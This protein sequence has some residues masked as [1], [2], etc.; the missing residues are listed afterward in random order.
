MISRRASA[1]IAIA[2]VTLSAAHAGEAQKQD[3]PRY[4]MLVFETR[5]CFYCDHFRYAVAPVYQNSKFAAKA[6]LQYVDVRQT[7]MKRLGLNAPI[8]IAPTTVL[9]RDGKEVN[10]IAGVTGPQDFLVLVDHMID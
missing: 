8:T 10:R 5:N 6:P 7:D 4:R 2:A 1:A 3:A 9:T